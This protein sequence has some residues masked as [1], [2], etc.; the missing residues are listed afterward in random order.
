[1]R[2]IAQ[3]GHAVLRAGICIYQLQQR[4]TGKQRPITDHEQHR[5]HSLHRPNTQRDR[6]R[7]TQLRH[8]VADYLTAICLR[9][10][11]DLIVARYDSYTSSIQAQSPI[12]R[13]ADHR[14]TPPGGQKLVAPIPFAATCC[15]QNNSQ[16][17]MLLHSRL[18][19]STFS[20]VIG[21]WRTRTPQALY[22]AS[23]IAGAGVLITISPMDFAPNGPVGS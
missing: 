23:A 3:T 22:T 16:L 10:P 14:S 11:D 18:P 17:H 9:N 21:R 15:Q 12:Y 2:I 19:R 5:I 6:M 13:A 8:I 7:L 20:A 1:M 4:R